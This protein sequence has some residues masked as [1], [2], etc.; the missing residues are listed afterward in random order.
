MSKLIF[1]TVFLLIA[2]ASP[3]NTQRHAPTEARHYPRL[4][5][6]DLP[7]YPALT[8]T[9]RISGKVDIEVIV[10]KGSVVDTQVKSTEIYV[11]DPQTNASYDSKAKETMAGKFLSDPSLANIKTWQFES[12]DRADFL[13]TYVYRIEGAETEVPENPKIE[14]DLPQLV[15]ITARPFKSTCSD[16]APQAHAGM[17]R[18]DALTTR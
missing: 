5:R 8:R 15:K 6:A 2:F 14:L 4:M 13:V 11:K 16:C 3:Q 1:T 17:I 7:L 10:E 9:L 12:Q 18:P